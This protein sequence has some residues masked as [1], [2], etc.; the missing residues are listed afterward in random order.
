MAIPS[1][2]MI[3]TGF[4]DGKL[5]SVLPESGVGDFSV[6]RGSGA[7]RVNKDGLI[8]DVRIISGELVTNGSFDSNINFWFKGGGN[9]SPLSWDNGKM[10]ITNDVAQLNSARQTVNTEIGKTYKVSAE[11]DSTNGLTPRLASTNPTASLIG[12]SGTIETLTYT[13][14]ATSTSSQIEL[15]NWQGTINQYN[16]WDNVSVK[17][18]TNDTDIP[19]LDYT[20]GGCP[21][22]LTEPQS[23]NLIP[24]S[25]DFSQSSWAYGNVTK[26]LSA[27]LSPNGVD[28]AYR[29]ENDAVSGNHF[30]RD[31]VTVLSGTT[32]TSSVFIK[33][34][35]R[36]IVS[37]GD[38]NSVN[39]LANFNLTNGTVTNISA[40]SSSIES[41]G[42]DWF[43]CTATITTT[44]TLLGV[45]LF[46][47]TL[48][49]G[50]DESGDFYIWGAQLEALPYSTSYIPTSGA[51]ATR[52]ADVVTGAG[53]SSTFNSTEGVLYAEI[54]ALADDGTQRAISIYKDG[55]LDNFITIQYNSVSNN[56]RYLYRQGAVSVSDL[57]FVVS[58]IKT[59]HK[60]AATWKQNEFKLFVDGFNVSEN[61]TGNVA[62]SNTFVGLD[63]KRPDG[64]LFY[65]KTKDL[66]VYNTALSDAELITL[67][68]I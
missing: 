31:N 44:T 58:D 61:L 27:V 42:N 57:N 53:D 30:V 12:T 34:G 16:L 1:L 17:E 33:K 50:K 52:L 64:N 19:R 35:T 3:P 67:T 36:D 5:Y 47:G 55:S 18:I 66:R 21:V 9:T 62:P 51:I 59:I 20:D 13:F 32:Y 46:S 65:G 49:A 26:S 54:A 60:I 29:I 38:G 4:K 15:F 56:I 23:T 39:I 11:V 48:Y 24:Y 22:L 37:I 40:T 43:R 45:M 41:Y 28:F 6:T 10:K 8:E 63:F 14:I 68:T 2:A 7:T 25:E